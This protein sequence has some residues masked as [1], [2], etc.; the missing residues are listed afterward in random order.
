MKIICF[1]E[2]YNCQLKISLKIGGYFRNLFVK[3]KNYAN[4]EINLG[5]LHSE[6]TIKITLRKLFPCSSD[7]FEMINTHNR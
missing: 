2:H 6:C 1:R 4:S 3:L 7:D 5:M